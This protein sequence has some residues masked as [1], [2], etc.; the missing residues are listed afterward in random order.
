M[1]ELGTG[2]A[3]SRNGQLPLQAAM[4]ALGSGAPMEMGAAAG[5]TSTLLPAEGA[6]DQLLKQ[7]ATSV[8]TLLRA[9][10]KG[11]PGAAAP[12]L[13]TLSSQPSPC[14]CCTHSS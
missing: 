2:Q 5:V 14:I 11:T 4:K 9:I 6:A 7:A 10:S 12:A 3:A 13:G 1:Q 8:P